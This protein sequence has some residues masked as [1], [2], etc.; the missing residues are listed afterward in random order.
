MAQ[1]ISETVQKQNILL[2]KLHLLR[3]DKEDIVDEVFKIH[4]SEEIHELSNKFCK[5]YNAS[6]IDDESKFFAIVYELSFVAPVKAID[7]LCKNPIDGVNKIIS[8][9][10]VRI[11]SDNTERLVVIVNSYDYNNTLLS[12]VEKNGP[13]SLSSNEKIITKLTSVIR[14]LSIQGIFG[15]NISPS[16]ILMNEEEDTILNLREFI[17]SYP[18]FHEED[19]YI[20]PELIECLQSSRR[21]KN[22]KQDIYALGITIFYSFS[23]HSPWTKFLK[24]EEYNENRLEH[25]SYKYLMNNLKTTERF[26]SFLRFTMQDSALIRWD[27][28]QIYDWLAGKVDKI[29]Y[30]SLNNNKYTIGFIDKNYS[31]PKSLSYAMFRFWEQANKF[32]RDTKFLQWAGKQQLSNDALASIKSLIDARSIDS[33]INLNGIAIH[34]TQKLA[35]LLSILDP[36]G[37]LRHD[38]IAVSA[39]SIPETLQYLQNSKRKILLEQ[40]IKIMQDKSWQNYLNIN[41]AGFLEET[42]SDEFHYFAAHNNNTSLHKNNERLIYSLNP[43]LPCLSSILDGKYVTDIKELLLALDSHAQKKPNNFTVDRHISAFIAAKLDLKDNIKPVILSNFPKFAEHL[44]V[45]S[46]SIINLLYQHEPDIKIT[47]ICKAIGLELVKLFDQY[48]HNTEFKKT[49]L[50]KIESVAQDGDISQIIAIFSN[51]QL[52][53]DDYNGY[54]EACKKAKSLEE[55]IMTL[56]TKT[57]SFNDAAILLGQKTTVLASYI[58]C[59]VAIVTII[60]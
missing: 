44:T 46:L 50:A 53:I 58:L 4:L 16:N 29:V 15:Y 47:Y 9:S 36:N 57:N 39:E 18:Y 5:Y 33:M 25:G 48:L 43:Y 22:C 27:T 60:I 35:K 10:I 41:S 30:D 12:Y 1:E 13:I 26:R 17:N 51:Q 24:P 28:R 40:V 20:A 34:S 21:T 54:Y 31:N 59:L 56:S 38:T 55:E 23:S 7:Y 32:I 19:Q 37:S 6:N 11:S 14:E 42:K 49:I 52:F 2:N 8:W 3:S 45:K